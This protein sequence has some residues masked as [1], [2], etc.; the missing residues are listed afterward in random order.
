M[1]QWVVRHPCFMREIANH[2]VQMH[3]ISVL[4]LDDTESTSHH[5]SVHLS[6]MAMLCAVYSPCNTVRGHQ[7]KCNLN[8]HLHSFTSQS[9]KAYLICLILKMQNYNVM[10]M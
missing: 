9:D 1:A 6:S 8:Y 3:I 5:I 7:K 4:T 10:H 2:D